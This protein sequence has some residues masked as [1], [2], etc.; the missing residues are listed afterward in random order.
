VSDAYRRAGVDLEAGAK[1]VELIRDLSADVS[2]G[3]VEG[4][5]GFA[6]LYAIGDDRFLAAATD[7]VGT[8]IEIARATGRLD[9]VGIDLVAMCVDD[10]V[11]TG[12]EPLFFLDYLAVGRVVPER[13]AA[14]VAG[15]AEGCRRAGCA[16]LGGETAEHPGVMEPDAFDLAGFCV[17][18]VEE[19]QRLGPQRVREGDVLLGLAASGLHSNGFSLVRAALF[20]RAGYDVDDDLP[21]LGRSLGDELLEPTAI[22]A[23][24]VLALARRGLVHAA[25]HVTGGGLP[26]NLPRA[27]PEGLGADVDETSWPV[28]PVF[29]LVREAAN[30]TADDMRA[31]FNMGIGMVLAVAPDA[32]DAV[33]AA[34]PA[35]VVIGGVVAGAGLR[36]VRERAPES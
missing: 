1:A 17:G 26:G 30:A 22:Y 16:L 6:G 32:V 19:S 15:V 10:V 5:G 12:S 14:I 28:P 13:V 21:R 36:Y 11:C 25:V 29:D 18:V 31:T 23:P 33:R 35:S 8:K 2:T 20:D 27:L 24:V 4:V 3:V 7:G 9:T 34:A